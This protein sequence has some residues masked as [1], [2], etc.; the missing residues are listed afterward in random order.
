MLKITTTKGTKL[1]H[2]PATLVQLTDKGF[3]I[4]AEDE[5][6]EL[7]SFELIK[8]YFL[9]KEVKITIEEI[10]RDTIEV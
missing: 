3:F 10:T 8:E 6:D 5:G 1:T 9:N 2:K 4:R 7:I